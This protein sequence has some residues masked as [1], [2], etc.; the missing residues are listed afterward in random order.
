M[1]GKKKKLNDR[2]DVKFSYFSRIHYGGFF[3]I[4]FAVENTILCVLFFDLD[5]DVT[6]F[7][8]EP[9]SL[10]LSFTFEPIQY[11]GHIECTRVSLY[12]RSI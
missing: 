11:K 8:S 10:T 1:P 2:L 7:T 12:R 9:F 5:R 6:D 3:G 4:E